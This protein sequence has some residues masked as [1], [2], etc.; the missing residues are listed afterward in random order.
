MAAEA[1]VSRSLPAGR[2]Q[3]RGREYD[4]GPGAEDRLQA[5]RPGRRPGV[6]ACLLKIAETE[7]HTA[8]AVGCHFV[9]ESAAK[10]HRVGWPERQLR[11]DRPQLQQC[12]TALCYKDRW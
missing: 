11:R 2:S 5:H 10:L 8:H 12:R 4:T 3:E 7:G 9:E 1:E 6:D